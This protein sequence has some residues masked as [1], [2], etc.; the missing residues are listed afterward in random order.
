MKIKITVPFLADLSS[1][2]SSFAPGGNINSTKC[3]SDPLMENK[4]DDKHRNFQL[5]INHDKCIDKDMT[6]K[7]YLLELFRYYFDPLLVRRLS[8]SDAVLLIYIVLSLICSTS[9][10]PVM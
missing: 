8:S 3:H 5:K 1:I 2:L 7:E 6:V 9:I 10:L 4:F